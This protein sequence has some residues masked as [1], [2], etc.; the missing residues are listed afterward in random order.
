MTRV[1]GTCFRVRPKHVPGWRDLGSQERARLTQPK[2]RNTRNV[3]SMF[4]SSETGK[5]EDRVSESIEGRTCIGKVSDST[6]L[7]GHG[8]G[9]SHFFGGFMAAHSFRKSR[10]YLLSL[11][12]K[13]FQSQV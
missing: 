2:S 6:L 3:R 5:Y 10:N 7:C 1:A 8:V 11:F 4:C 12:S 9:L 13:L